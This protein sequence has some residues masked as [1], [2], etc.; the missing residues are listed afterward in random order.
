[1]QD[2]SFIDA[3]KDKG[4]TNLNPIDPQKVNSERI[5]SARDYAALLVIKHGTQFLPIFERLEVEVEKQAEVDLAIARAHE[6][7]RRCAAA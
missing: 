3:S 6:I 1:M 2:C 7:V 4:S 5:A